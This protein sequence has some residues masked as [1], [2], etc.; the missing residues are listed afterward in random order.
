MNRQIFLALFLLS[1]CA[2]FPMQHPPSDPSSEYEYRLSLY[3]SCVRDAE[4]KYVSDN[5]SSDEFVDAVQSACGREFEGF[6]QVVYRS[7]SQAAPGG[8]GLQQADLVVQEARAAIRQRIIR[9]LLDRRIASRK[10]RE[11]DAELDALPDAPASLDE[12]EVERRRRK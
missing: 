11:G 6:S 2:G 3:N 7:L 10:K 9:D 8:L 5:N 4:D 1:G 12:A